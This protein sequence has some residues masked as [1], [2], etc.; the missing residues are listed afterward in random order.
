MYSVRDYFLRARAV[1]GVGGWWFCQSF[2]VPVEIAG[3]FE[4]I[5]TSVMEVV[6]GN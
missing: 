1:L 6:T 2:F 3:K 4:S 5:R